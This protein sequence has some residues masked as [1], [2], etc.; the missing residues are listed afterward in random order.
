[1]PRRQVNSRA[2]WCGTLLW[3]DRRCRRWLGYRRGRKAGH[4]YVAG[5]SSDS[6]GRARQTHSRG[7]SDAFAAKFN[8]S[9]GLVWHPLWGRVL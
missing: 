4:V 9:G 3:G 6:L 8:S 2:A 7:S 5:Y 1:M